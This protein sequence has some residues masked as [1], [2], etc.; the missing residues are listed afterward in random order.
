MSRVPTLSVLFVCLGNHCRSPA[1][2]AIAETIAARRQMQGI[3]FDSAGTSDEH[4][5]D[6]PHALTVAE[7]ARRGYRVDHRG[8]PVHPDD[9]AD[10]D[11]ILAMDAANVRE[12]KRL[13]GGLDQR[14]GPY[15]SLE[16]HQVQLLR[17]WDPYAM[18]DDE[19]LFDPWGDGPEA[20]VEMYDVLE[21]TIP[22][23]LDHLA[24]LRT[25]L[26]REV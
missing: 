6:A 19:D 9:F 11:L 16:P 13:G 21:R 12:L 20:Y 7:G 3:T 24:W 14:T 25:D 22:A 5:G 10:F 18:P 23:L 15:G 1:A 26:A 4:R 2:H 8:R 17:R